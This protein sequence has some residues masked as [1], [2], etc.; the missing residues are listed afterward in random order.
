MIEAS[1]TLLN[2]QRDFVEWH[3]GRSPYVFWGLDVDMPAVVERVAAARQHLDGLLLAGYQRQPHVTLELCGFAAVAPQA[4]DEFGGAYLLAQFAAL[5]QAAPGPFEIDIGALE[6]FTSAPYLRVDDAGQRLAAL[7]DCLAVEGA[8]RLAGDYTPHVT[9]G[10]YADAW[11][12]ASVR[13]RLREFVAAEPLSCRIV[14]ICLMA[15][16]PAEIGGPLRRLG[17]FHLDRR[18]MHWHDGAEQV[19]P[20]IRI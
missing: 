5:R 13:S 7:R 8:Y 20:G 10:L 4:V 1:H 3:R 11:P 2:E 17:D 12:A 6:S 19:L 15:Y 16:A 18:E 14:R 9:V